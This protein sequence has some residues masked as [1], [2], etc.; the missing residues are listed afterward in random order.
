MSSTS[1]CVRSDSFLLCGLRIAARRPVV[2]SVFSSLCV[3]GGNIRFIFLLTHFQ[4]RRID[5]TQWNGVF[6]ASAI[7]ARF[8]CRPT[9]GHECQRTPSQAEIARYQCG[10]GCHLSVEIIYRLSCRYIFV[11]HATV[12]LG[13]TVHHFRMLQTAGKCFHAP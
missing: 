8:A 4:L 11:E 1:I 13:Q 2:N 9:K 12:K 5:S 7:A 3:A 10:S 6:S